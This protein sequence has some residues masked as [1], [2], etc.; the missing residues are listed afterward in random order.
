ML[1]LTHGYSQHPHDVVGDADFVEKDSEFVLVQDIDVFSLCEHHLLPFHGIC[2]VAY[3]PSGHV[4]GLSKIA[5][6]VDTYAR[7]LQVQERLTTQIAEAIESV[8]N[9]HGVMVL[10]SCTHMCM[11]MRGVQKVGTRTTTTANRGRYATD[12]ALRSE[13]LATLRASDSQR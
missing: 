5:R 3:L 11:S 12:A 1:A 7:R 8:T 13:F 2:H 4:I 10:I 6:I 9:A